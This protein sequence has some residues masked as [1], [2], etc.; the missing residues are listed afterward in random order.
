[1][2]KKLIIIAVIVAIV[3]ALLIAAWV[4]IMPKLERYIP[5]YNDEK[6]K[7]QE[8]KTYVLTIEKE[9]F[10]QEVAKELYDNEIIINADRFLNYLNEHY[11][12]FNWLNGI[13]ELNANMSYQELCEALQKPNKRITYTKFVVPEGKTVPE[14]AKIVEASELCSAEEFLA[15]ADSYDYDYYFM[16]ELKKRDQSLIA[17][18]LEGFLFPATYE[19][20]NDTVTATAIV[21]KML[22]TFTQYVTEEMVEKA[23]ALGLSLNE[24][25]T[26]GAVIQAEAFSVE[27]MAG[28]SSVFWNRLNSSHMKQL[29]SDP[30]M[31]YTDTLE[32]LPHYSQKMADAYST[33]SCV[34]LP[35]GPTNCPGVATLK[36]VLEPDE[37]EYFYFVTDSNGEFY[38]N[39]TLKGHNKTIQTLK[40]QGL[41]G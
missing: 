11:P 27:S 16:D 29:Q 9:D 31:F 18:K 10:A 40:K 30:T 22:H 23:K 41:W 32:S 6:G 28:V 19:F 25:V 36:A 12:N 5:L 37:T 39:E 8:D 17:Y 3:L 33:Y 24:F 7:S 35:V 2:K 13:Y 38:F 26:F 21:D 4:I 14:I 1:M 15:A 20:R 34:G